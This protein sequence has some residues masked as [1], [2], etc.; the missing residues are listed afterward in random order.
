MV[1][2]R[3]NPKGDHHDHSKRSTS[4]SG[5][6]PSQSH[7]HRGLGTRPHPPATKGLA[8]RKQAL[9]T[10]AYKPPCDLVIGHTLRA[11]GAVSP[12]QLKKG[13]AAVRRSQRYLVLGLTLAAV[14]FGI[15]TAAP[16]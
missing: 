13:G 12:H 14:P 6:A 1:R 8:R 9:F 2:G 10:K 5:C 16:A 3:T 15:D 4:G 7:D 11:Q